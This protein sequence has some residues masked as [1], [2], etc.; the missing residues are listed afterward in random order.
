[1][2]TGA[3]S[4]R[5]VVLRGPS[6]SGKTT[7]ALA[8]RPL[9]GPK[10][11]LIHQDYFRRELLHS[12][13]RLKRAADAAALIIATARQ[14]LDRGYDVILDGIFN[15]RDYADALEQLANDHAGTTRIYAFDLPLDET[16]RRH[17]T[18][19]LSAEF[20]DDKLRD[21]YDGWQP[22]PRLAETRVT[23]DV[24]TDKLVA[25]I[26]RDVERP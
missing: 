26:L 5:L 6:A 20:G 17:A 4:T 1:M 10:T 8:L 21:W 23:A 15:L 24:T 19:P 22:L 7:A 14:A 11:A 9:L 13:E 3:A 18:R 12:D 25:M 2:P 16:I